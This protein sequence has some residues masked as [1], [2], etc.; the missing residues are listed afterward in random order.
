MDNARRKGD[1]GAVGVVDW[2]NGGGEFMG[3][4]TST[5]HPLAHIRCGQLKVNNSIVLKGGIMTQRR[6]IR[7]CRE[8]HSAEHQLSTRFHGEQWSHPWQLITT[9]ERDDA[10]GW[11]A[12]EKE[13]A[14]AGHDERAV[15]LV[16][17]V[18]M[19]LHDRN[20]GVIERGMEQ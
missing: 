10:V 13:S 18:R 19:K 9:A 1:R 3:R 17:L 2:V 4:G 6:C 15:E 14:P 16:V 7:A 8:Y 11:D 5:R 20:A 12:L